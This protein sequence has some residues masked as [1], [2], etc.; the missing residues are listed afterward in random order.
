M[1]SLPWF[2]LA[3]AGVVLVLV[4]TGRRLPFFAAR[5]SRPFLLHFFLAAGFVALLSALFTSSWPAYKLPWLSRIYAV[6]PTIRSLPFSW[7]HNGLAANQTGGMLAVLTAFAAVVAAAPRPSLAGGGRKGCI[8][9]STA[10]FLT[11]SGVVVVFMTGSRAA[12][13]GLVVAV[14]LVLVLRS[15][16]WRWAWTSV[17]A[18][19]VIGLAASGRLGTVFRAFVRD[20]TLSGELVSRLD[21][22][23]SS[24]KAIQDHPFTGIGLG[25]YNQVIPVRYPYS[26]VALAFPVSQAHN[27]FLDVALSIGLAGLVGFLLLLSGLVLMSIRGL[28][29]DY[30]TRVLSLCSLASITAF[31]VYGLTDSMSFSRPTSFIL[32]LWPCVLA[33]S[34]ARATAKEAVAQR[35]EASEAA[36]ER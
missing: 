1:Q 34:E 25:V 7:A 2:L 35:A 14:P 8:Y 28:K 22:W 17:A 20:Q 10:I 32:W 26:T 11:V 33:I 6:L 13:V 24:L 23:S 36:H 4:V 5:L 15:R 29:R 30:P 3:I 16:A 12:L 21:I 18:V 19:S 27:V 9:R 31:T